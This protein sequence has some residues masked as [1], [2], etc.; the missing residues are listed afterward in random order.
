MTDPTPAHK[1]MT[2]P[3]SLTS[4]RGPFVCAQRPIPHFTQ[5]AYPPPRFGEGRESAGNGGLCLSRSHANASPYRWTYPR[6]DVLE[7]RDG[8]GQLIATHDACKWSDQP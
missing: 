2:R 4:E 3:G 5:S 7:C 6:P 1:P 8:R